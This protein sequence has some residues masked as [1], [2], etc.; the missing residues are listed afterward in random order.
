LQL[1]STP[2]GHG[3]IIAGFSAWLTQ[4]CM[5]QGVRRWSSFD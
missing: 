5:V 1:V 4:I 3:T 2:L